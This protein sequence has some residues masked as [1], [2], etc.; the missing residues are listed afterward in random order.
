MSIREGGGCCTSLAA[1]I[2]DMTAPLLYSSLVYSCA[3]TRGSKAAETLETF[4][5][6]TCDE[7]SGYCTYIHQSAAPFSF[8]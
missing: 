8:L 4:M 7:R 6:A 1:I 5:L 3:E 2:C